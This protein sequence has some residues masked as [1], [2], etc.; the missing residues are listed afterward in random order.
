MRD[1]RLEKLADVLVNYS[2]KVQLGDD[3]ILS[4]GGVSQRPKRRM[5]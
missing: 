4:A 2:V 5:R 3:V 1:S